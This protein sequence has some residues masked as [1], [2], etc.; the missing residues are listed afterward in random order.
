M[1][2]RIFFSAQLMLLDSV[3]LFKY[4]FIYFFMT[5]PYTRKMCSSVKRKIRNAGRSEQD[6]FKVNKTRS[7][8]TSLNRRANTNPLKLNYLH[9][10]VVIQNAFQN[11]ILKI[12][13]I[14][15]S[16]VDLLPISP[17]FMWF[18]RLSDQR[19]CLILSNSSYKTV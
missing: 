5:D 3:G 19:A 7:T 6:V 4:T 11:N 9:V 8:S 10:T 16:N 13:H 15:Y 12:K 1:L 14:Q 2:T 18:H 17:F